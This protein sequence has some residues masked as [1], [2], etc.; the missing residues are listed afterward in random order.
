M[1]RLVAL[2]LLACGCDA[3]FGLERDEAPI[4]AAPPDVSCAEV[5]PDE[6]GDCITDADDNCPGQ[7]N[8][9]QADF[10]DDKVGDECDPN[11]QRSGDHIVAFYG[12]DDVAS[13]MTAWQDLEAN[14]W[15]FEPGRVVHSSLTDSYA[16]LLRNPAIDEVEI[17]VEAAFDFQQWGAAVNAGS[18]ISVFLDDTDIDGHTCWATPVTAG[19]EVYVQ[20]GGNGIATR[21]SLRSLDLGDIV[22]LRLTRRA[23]TG[24]ASD[25]LRCRATVG[26]DN[27][28]DLPQVSRS[29]TWPAGRVAVHANKAAFAVRWIAI[30]ASP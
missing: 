9:E 23:L 27:P 25:V 14:N 29:K 26:T 15:T 21:S 7:P 11:R 16:V 20:E 10:D 17:T 24:G 19:T 3:V 8:P 28:I 12:F 18:R 6:D 2:C 22:T 4:D 5:S 1:H 13:S 30:Y